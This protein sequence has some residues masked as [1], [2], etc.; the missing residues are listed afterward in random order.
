LPSRRRD[1]A[2]SGE[3]SLGSGQILHE[4]GA[5]RIAGRDHD[6]RHR[7]RLFFYRKRCRRSGGDDHVHFGGYEL[8][9]KR[10]KPFVVSLRPKVI[11]DDIAP[12]LIAEFAQPSPE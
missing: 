1:R 12:F 9:D 6:K 10:R 3:I 4:T 5:D 2:Q 8:I 7:L 11:D